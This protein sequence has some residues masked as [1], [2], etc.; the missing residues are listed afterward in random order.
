MLLKL[1]LFLICL[2]LSGATIL[3]AFCAA[4]AS[5]GKKTEDLMGLIALSS[6]LYAPM[7]WVYIIWSMVAP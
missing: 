1:G 6:F 5:V 4:E 7:F 3:A 2:A